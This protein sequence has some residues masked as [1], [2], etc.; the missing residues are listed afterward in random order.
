MRVAFHSSLSTFYFSLSTLPSLERRE[1][2]M[3]TRKLC[4][5]VLVITVLLLWPGWAAASKPAD[6][7]IDLTGE[8]QVPESSGPSGWELIEES[9]RPV[10]RVGDIMALDSSLLNNSDDFACLDSM[11]WA[12]WV[13]FACENVTTCERVAVPVACQ[14]TV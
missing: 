4:A 9:A 7:P 11:M 13:S 10:W 12:F 6:M 8:C 2:F 1:S 3:S 5:S 14:G